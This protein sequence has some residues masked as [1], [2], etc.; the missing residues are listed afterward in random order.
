MTGMSVVAVMP[1]TELLVLAISTAEVA[2]LVVRM[3]VVVGLFSLAIGI[4]WCVFRRHE[5]IG[6]ATSRADPMHV[7]TS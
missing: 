1:P 2:P 3:Y 5:F 7:G 6:V 4:S